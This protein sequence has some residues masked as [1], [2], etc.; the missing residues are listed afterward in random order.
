MTFDFN[1]EKNDLLFKERGI[2]F[3]Q[4]IEA[5]AEKGIL[6]NIKHPNEEQYRHQYMLVVEYNNYTYCVPYVIDGNTWFFENHF[7]K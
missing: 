5:I 2:T 1:K 6:L 4:I 7:S 3:Y